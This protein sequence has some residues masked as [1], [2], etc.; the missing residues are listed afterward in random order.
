MDENA[1]GVTI[2]EGTGTASPL[3]AEAPVYDVT[4]TTDAVI[5]PVK[6]EEPTLYDDT[7]AEARL[8][9][10]PTAMYAGLDADVLALQ[11]PRYKERIR[12]AR[13]AGI[14]DGMIREVLSEREAETAYT[15]TPEERDAEFGRTAETKE[16]AR[17]VMRKNGIDLIAA[18]TRLK[19]EDVEERMDDADALGVSPELFFRNEE[20]YKAL[21]PRANVARGAWEGAKAGWELTTAQRDYAEFMYPLRGAELTEEQ[22]ATAA[23]YEEKIARLS[24]VKPRGLAAKIALNTATLAAQQIQGV[25]AG[26]GAF[27][28]MLGA[29]AALALSATPG[30][31]L[32]AAGTAGITAA[33]SAAAGP[34][35]E[36]AAVYGT[37]DNV[38]KSEAVSLYNGL[39]EAGVPREQAL[40][41][42]DA[43]GLLNAAIEV[44]NF[45]AVLKSVV[46]GAGA[47]AERLSRTLREKGGVKTL[48][49]V[50][51]V[52]A[53][54]I[55]KL[56][57]FGGTIRSESLEEM[58]QAAVSALLTEGAKR[59]NG[60]DTVSI[61]EAVAEI[62]DDGAAAAK[63]MFYGGIVGAAANTAIAAA[64]ARS[65]ARSAGTAAGT[66][67]A[68]PA[69]DVTARELGATEAEPVA[70]AQ[71]VQPV[72]TLRQDRLA[73]YL[74]DLPEEEQRRICED[75]GVP[76][77]DVSAEAEPEAEAA[78]GPAK[79]EVSREAYEAVAAS[80]PDFAE[81]APPLETV[82]ARRLSGIAADPI[83]ADTTLA[84]RARDFR[85]DVVASLKAAG[86]DTEQARANAQIAA[87]SLFSMAQMY[88]AE[89]EGGSEAFFDRYARSLK[90]RS[91]GGEARG[92]VTFN[93]PAGY[94]VIALMKDK[95]ASTFVHE[96]GHVQ[97][98][99]M[100]E[101]AAEDHAPDA[102]AR[103]VET[104][105]AWLKE[106]GIDISGIDFK[107]AAA[108]SDEQSA[109]LTEAHEYF[110][111]GFESYLRDGAAPTPGL[112]GV[113]EKFKLW[114]TRLYRDARDLNVNLSPEVRGLF[115][116]LI[117]APSELESVND[118]DA[119]LAEEEERLRKMEADEAAAEAEARDEVAAAANLEASATEAAPEAEEN[120]LARDDL[121]PEDMAFAEA[122][123]DG[124][125]GAKEIADALKGRGVVNAVTA[126]EYKSLLITGEDLL[127]Q[128]W[129]PP[130]YSDA[131]ELLD[132]DL[133]RQRDI[134]AD[135]I[136]AAIKRMG[137]L[138]SKGPIGVT[139]DTDT[140][141][142]LKYIDRALF[143]DKS[144][145]SLEDLAVDLAHEG[146]RWPGITPDPREKESLE[147]LGEL[148]M[149]HK[150]KAHRAY[151][152]DTAAVPDIALTE[153]R[154]PY[155]LA[156]TTTDEVRR[157]ADK[158]AAALRKEMRQLL[159]EVEKSGD[160]SQLRSEGPRIYREMALIEEIQ[161]SIPKPPAERKE[162]AARSERPAGTTVAARDAE[163]RSIPTAEAAESA[164]RTQGEYGAAEQT[165]TARVAER[166]ALRTAERETRAAYFA[167]RKDEMEAALKARRT[168]VNEAVSAALAKARARFDARFEKQS[169]AA[170]AKLA[171]VKQKDREAKAAALKK[172]KER[173]EAARKRIAERNARK[174]EM[175][176]LISRISRA[177][178]AQSVLYDYKEQIAAVLA[179][180]SLGKTRR[181]GK[182]DLRDVSMTTL[183]DLADQVQQIRADGH[184]AYVKWDTERRVR[185][186]QYFVDLAGTVLP[187]GADKI[188]TGRED[189][190]KD[191][192]GLTGGLRR[193]ADWTYAATLGSQ[194][195]FDWL[196][197]GRG[198]FKSKW[199]EVFVD[200][201]NAAKD[202]ESRERFKRFA[203][204]ENKMKD[205]GVSWRDVGK[206]TAVT[207]TLSD[208]STLTQTFTMDALM[209]I[210]A[211]MK[212]EK[213]RAAI[214]Y[215]NFKALSENSPEDAEALA[216]A[217]VQKLKPEFKELA[218]FVLEDYNGENYERI[219]RKLID[220]FNYGMG[221]EENYTPIRRLRSFSLS[222]TS[223]TDVMKQLQGL[224][225]QA[226][227]RAR[228]DKSFMID[229]VEISNAHQTPI[230][231]GLL[232]AWNDA[233]TTQEHAAAF[234]K[235]TGDMASVL[236]R[237]TAEGFS[238]GDC[239]RRT[240]GE[241][242]WHTT[243]RFVNLNVQS[244]VESAHNAVNALTN[245]L[246]R[247]MS[248]TYLALN[249]S[250]ALKQFT[251]LPRF[252]ISAG[253]ARILAS[254]G[255]LLSE[256]GAFY[257][258]IYELDPQMRD[259]DPNAFFR[260]MRL[261]NGIEGRADYARNK[262]MEAAMWPISFMDRTVACIGWDATYSAC[263]RRGMSRS[264]AAR[265][266][267]RAVAMTQQVPAMKDMPAIW[268]QNGLAK[269]MMLFTSDA[270][271]VWGMTVYDLAQQI[272]SGNAPEVLR[273][274]SALAVSAAMFA[275]ITN[276]PPAA[277]DDESWTEWMMKAMRDQTL[278]SVPLVGK[279]LM[280]AWEEIFDKQFRGSN[281]D[282]V[283]TPLVNVLKGAKNLASEKG[284]EVL[285]NGLTREEY[286]CWQVLEGLSVA[287]S[288]L[289]VTMMRRLR[290]MIEADDAGDAIKI[291]IGMRREKKRHTGR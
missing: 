209:D 144:G 114:L 147:A 233:V 105:K 90:V 19:P 123:E 191:Y 199:S 61:E 242:A 84:A 237:K 25:T 167:G 141:R 238:L 18:R 124:G 145:H 290:T 194:R 127:A 82:I 57:D 122:F 108:L 125:P 221:K 37:V 79:V 253:P 247:N 192:S 3:A 154:L 160:R 80:R 50:P 62:L 230:E 66:D 235:I 45:E 60:L 189:L 268:H 133:K 165:V 53:A 215:G 58:G 27:L 16:A 94:D 150:K 193:A 28:P 259:R 72:V 29:G 200:L 12:E 63:Q 176:T 8:A 227:A 136:A 101:V 163:R 222:G 234:A 42:S 35:A 208:G 151:E 48:L 17:L 203:A 184:E 97:L 46:P 7:G 85:Q 93:D 220:A 76:Y 219:N 248:L 287:A 146:Y 224:V 95:D 78:G 272:R 24:G 181:Q 137:G 111:R 49:A 23:E 71:L 56:K 269:L 135:E 168:A 55:E 88:G 179:D 64:G 274:V 197:S 153:E 159:A 51:S 118:L 207:A 277:D 70:A 52:R 170:K 39:V 86:Y 204:L 11:F 182:I 14:S 286:G 185:R 205:L 252:L 236:V 218:D 59:Y 47:L 267:Q 172:L 270:A 251:S 183:R 258:R 261:E 67:A 228:L 44:G 10:E 264:D 112:R 75:L 103:D 99:T 41:V 243:Q 255:R 43:G 102:L 278:Q 91:E 116:R 280:T 120:Y 113:F 288:G 119:A 54:I 232:S 20:V 214:L 195:F 68:I 121:P 198:T 257:E 34:A 212:N 32:A 186:A 126:A 74:Q 276:G 21:K 115:D 128:D 217:C 284:D 202:E 178:R 283:V 216:A 157:I 131:E 249:V 190:K 155:L 6:A 129:L 285:K 107:D 92:S 244:D 229:R 132:F 100:L 250:T 206:T 69:A 175:L 226:G 106:N 273:T 109:A 89:A 156:A 166:E 281:Y 173:A 65:A 266:A 246:A 130:R 83:E 260:V 15:M 149:N 139:F 187:H 279:S 169:E 188:V 239:I 254:C 38:R 225:T 96:W 138:K 104:V 110:A 171:A 177:A 256:R 231:L 282:A 134:Q 241:E 9:A 33:L 158:R 164:A 73:G 1:A 223:D 240:K 161:E 5:E 152:L 2:E 210:Y 87:K 40:M 174:K 213:K 263:L 271:P 13:L 162:T 211:G 142:D 265:A 98:Q 245:R 143:N 140:V 291:L 22:R 289:P 275:M 4:S 180:Y 36:A 201:P 196:G 117:A 26:E 77:E 148:L 262:L 81:A 31:M 30:G